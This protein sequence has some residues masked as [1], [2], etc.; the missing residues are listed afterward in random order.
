MIWTGGLSYAEKVRR[1]SEWHE[2][3]AWYPVTIDIVGGRHIK[4]WL[5]TLS[6]KSEY[7]DFGG[8]CGWVH[9]YGRI[10]RGKG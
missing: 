2:W 10:N 9:K 8:G 1:K 5:E 7:V 4:A 3:F 6:R